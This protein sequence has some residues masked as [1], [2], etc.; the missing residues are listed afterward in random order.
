MLPPDGPGG[1]GTPVPPSPPA[2]LSDAQLWD[3]YVANGVPN[4]S[5]TAL[6]KQR[7]SL[8]PASTWDHLV[9]NGMPKDSATALAPLAAGGPKPIDPNESSIAGTI[10]RD[11]AA[12][13]VR[14][15]GEAVGGIPTFL[16]QVADF[17]S[18]G[19][20]P[21]PALGAGARTARGVWDFLRGTTSPPDKPPTPGDPFVPGPIESLAAPVTNAIAAAVAAPGNAIAAEI[22]PS[23]PNHAVPGWVQR[24]TELAAD[25][26]TQALLGKAAGKAMGAVSAGRP[27]TDLDY[28]RQAAQNTDGADV[29]TASASPAGGRLIY[30]MPDAARTVRDV[31]PVARQTIDA[32]LAADQGK[33][34]PQVSDLA[35]Q[36]LGVPSGT[37]RA[38]AA[39]VE[40][41]RDAAANT[42]YARVAAM[43]D[44]R[45]QNVIA[46]AIDDPDF[47]AALTQGKRLQ[48][49]WGSPLKPF[50]MIPGTPGTPATP[51]TI[52]GVALPDDFL[53]SNP[54]ERSAYLQSRMGDANIVPGSP[55]TPPTPATLPPSIPMR[56]VD[57]IKKG[58]DATISH[59]YNA[60]NTALGDA[61]T[62]ARG[63]WMDAVDADNAASVANGPTYA[64]V[65]Q[66]YGDPSEALQLGKQG[67]SDL[68]SPTVTAD[69]IT[70]TL[71]N[72]SDVGR[73]LYLKSALQRLQQVMDNAS[74]SATGG[75]D[76]VK[77]VYGAVGGRDKLAAL[78]SDPDAF[79]VF[80]DGMQQLAQ[81]RAATDFIT[82][83]SQ[84][85]GKTE[86][87]SQFKA[88]VPAAKAV[89]VLEVAKSPF[90]AVVSAPQ[91]IARAVADAQARSLAEAVA[92]RLVAP[93]DQTLVALRSANPSIPSVPSASIAAI[94][95]LRQAS[96]QPA[97]AP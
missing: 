36:A 93:A 72:A 82:K 49:L 58:L 96:E 51:A 41:A 15:P 83:G 45:D 81:Q 30:G 78:I 50:K 24:A 88:G 44:I 19:F 40:G 57:A 38:D 60:G 68:T 86:A 54:A 61:L 71:Q 79:K 90:K 13:A 8:G 87:V 65:R 66:A 34:I 47:Q 69:D 4:D 91:S 92:R 5:A 46:T 20:N 62:S 42:G 39:S 63:R 37:L 28:L 52:N 11:A 16:T 33:V 14:A 67:A 89:R 35:E 74:G 94:R 26:G 48:R 56:T 32:A 25:V 75:A 22:R 18:S 53:P 64:D 55:A 77:K 76:V 2:P 70:G 84:T 59:A 29:A 9:A 73:R 27:N 21:G 6:V 97:G 95:A 12:G 85:G 10:G 1:P 80:D 31:S 3:H 7:A 43:P 23:S 17:A